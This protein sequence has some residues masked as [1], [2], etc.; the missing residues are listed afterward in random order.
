MERLIKRFVTVMALS[1]TT[2]LMYAQE[3]TSKDSLHVKKLLDG[4]QELILNP[5][6]V[7]SIDFGN[8]A[9]TPRISK[10]K[11][12]MHFDESLPRVLPKP[13]VVLTL[14]PYTATTPY[15]WDPVYQKKIRV[16]KNTWRGDPFYELRQ[17]LYTKSSNISLGKGGVYISGGAIGGL[18]LMA[19]FTRDF[20]SK[21]RLETR[22]RTLE[23]LRTYGDS[24]NVM[25]NV[26]IEQIAR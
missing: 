1:L 9:G 4:E 3:W 23:V 6:A 20:W 10:E 25:I 18:D 19:M 17:L 12:W 14:S 2:L 24:T 21:K 26:P 16:T 15:D 22:D 7:K 8:A 11:S 13:K 5:D